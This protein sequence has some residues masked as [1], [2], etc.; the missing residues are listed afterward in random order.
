M[1]GEMDGVVL[2][3][4]VVVPDP[5]AA[6]LAEVPDVPPPVDRPHNAGVGVTGSAARLTTTNVSLR[7]RVASVTVSRY[8]PGAVCITAG[9]CT[10]SCVSVPPASTGTDTP[11]SVT[12]G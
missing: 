12:A 9:I 4:P 1:S 3:V 10:V 8:V 11:S 2:I 6:T 7:C 5:S